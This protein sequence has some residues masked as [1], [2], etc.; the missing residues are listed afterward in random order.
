[1]SCLLHTGAR[2]RLVDYGTCLVRL[3]TPRVIVRG[4]SDLSGRVSALLGKHIPAHRLGEHAR[5]IS[6]G[7]SSRGALGDDREYRV[8]L[9][10]STGRDDACGHGVRMA[11]ISQGCLSY[12]ELSRRLR[13]AHCAA[14]LST[15]RYTPGFQTFMMLVWPR[16]SSSTQVSV[17]GLARATMSLTLYTGVTQEHFPAISRRGRAR[18]LDGTDSATSSGP[19]RVAR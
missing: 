3:R 7:K 11:S 14:Y 4:P 8:L 17:A 9:T 1:M 18:R 16:R 2:Q 15:C 6:R 10:I 12:G 13:R 5:A 19:G